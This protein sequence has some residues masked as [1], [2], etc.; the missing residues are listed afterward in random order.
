MKKK[1]LILAESLTVGG[2]SERV[3]A[4][5][6]TELYERGYEISY[7]TLID[8]KPRYKFK[9]DYYT[10][11]QDDYHGNIL[12]L[13]FNLLRDSP[14]IKK[15]CN[16]LDVDTIISVA[17]EANFHAVLSRWLFRN[18]VRI[19]VSQHMN[20][21]IHLYSKL[22][23]FTINFF[24]SRADKTVCVSKVIEKILNES[25]NVKNTRTIY[26]MM[27]IENN[28]KLS[29]KELPLKYKQLFEGNNFNFIN[30]GRLTR[31]KGQWFLIR[32]F[33]QVVD[34]Y[35]N[36]RLFLLGDGDLRKE[37]ED[38]ISKLDLNQNVFLLGDQ[39]NVFPFLKSSDCFISTSLYEG[40]PM[41][42][43]EALSM[44]LP[45]I[46]SDCKTGPREILCPELD[47][48]K[49]IVYP[50]YAKYGI[51][52]QPF[53]GEFIFKNLEEAPLDESE[54]MLSHLMIEMI[55][56]PDLRGKHLNRGKMSENFNEDQ[57]FRT[58]ESII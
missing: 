2:G 56:D 58:W 10:L 27:D 51:L 3:A 21:G 17:E 28:I 52:N 23:T 14:R 25:F 13:L 54:D 34:H 50:C 45:I 6:G 1:I 43:I 7:L 55:N 57:I 29:Q 33:R 15:I 48:N 12:K 53:T 44:N 22:K 9:G 8:K 31:Q 47:P 46:S 36:A 41:V 38:L 30:M 11:D 40:L 5:L 42:L 18:N 39:E 49:E 19:I 4:L 16:D 32:S 24:Y 20:P 35:E 26:N 37:L